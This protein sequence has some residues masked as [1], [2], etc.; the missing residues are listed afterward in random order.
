MK[1]TASEPGL[2]LVNGHQSAF[3][4]I[5]TALSQIII[6]VFLPLLLLV[7]VNLVTKWT[8]RFPFSMILL[9]NY[10]TQLL[11]YNSHGVLNLCGLQIFHWL[12]WMK[13]RS[14]SVLLRF[15]LF[16]KFWRSLYVKPARQ[17]VLETM[18]NINKCNSSNI[19][20][21]FR[22]FF[23]RTALL[24]THAITDTKPRSRVRNIYI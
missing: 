12:L 1:S 24:R 17:L 4:D 19:K 6:S 18:Y 2:T 3:F 15:S 23:S 14:K 11:T 16:V 22:D 21:F 5:L 9:W 13:G 20:T 7:S 8:C 10:R